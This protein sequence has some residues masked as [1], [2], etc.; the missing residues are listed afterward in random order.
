MT[1]PNDPMDLTMASTKRTRENLIVE[2]NEGTPNPK[3]KK[4]PRSILKGKKPEEN[5]DETKQS[6][7]DAEQ[8]IVGP[9][10]LLRD[11]GKDDATI[12]NNLHTKFDQVH[13]TTASDEEDDDDDQLNATKNKD[14][15]HTH[16]NNNKTYKNNEINNNHT[17]EAHTDTS[18]Q[19]EQQ[20]E[21][22]KEID[23]K[24]DEDN[25]CLDLNHGGF[26]KHTSEWKSITEG[27]MNNS[28]AL[29]TADEAYTTDLLANIAEVMKLHLPTMDKDAWLKVFIQTKDM[30]GARNKKR[31]VRIFG[32][33]LARSDPTTLFSRDTFDGNKLLATTLTTVWAAAYTLYGA[34]WLKD[35]IDLGPILAPTALFKSCA[36]TDI[37]QAKPFSAAEVYDEA[38]DSLH[39]LEITMKK[40]CKVKGKGKAVIEPDVWTAAM[41]KKFKDPTV[42][43]V[44]L[45]LANTP[46]SLFK[47]LQLLNGNALDKIAITTI[48]TG[49]HRLLGQNTPNPLPTQPA[50]SSKT[51]P[52]SKSTPPKAKATE[53]TSAVKF[54]AETKA[55]QKPGN[56]LFISKAKPKP[57]ATLGPASK[58]KYN[59]YYKVK[60]PTT[61]NPFGPKA[62]EE[63]TSHFANLTE[64][65][66]SIDKKAEVLPWYDNNSAKPL[67]KGS[68]DLKTKE[69]L[70]KYTPNV[71]FAQGKNTWLRFHIAHDVNKEKFADTEAFSDAKLQ[72]SYDKVQAKK[73]SIWGWMLGGIPETANLN[74]MKEACENHPLLKAFQ[75]EARSQVIRVFSGKQDTPVHLQVKAIHIIGDDKL[76]AKG[77]KAFNSVFGSRNDSGYPQQRV[78]RFVPNIADNRFPATQ[79]RVK[80][81]VK[82]MGKQKKIV[83]DAKTIYTDTICGLHYYV[84]QIG[85]TLCQILM[86]M[87][88]THDPD[89]Q[90]F[91]AVDE[92]TYGSYAVAFTVHRDRMAE[93]TSLIP[94]LNIVMEAK[95]GASIWEW[96]TD[97][98]KD[99]SQGY[100]YDAILGRL[101][102]MDEEADDDESS[103]ESEEDN[104][105]VIE[106]SESLNLSSAKSTEKGDAFDLDL[107]FMLD[108]ENP[109][110]QYG[111]S[112][113]VKSFKSTCQ[114]KRPIDITSSDEEDDDDSDDMNH[115][116][117]ATQIRKKH[118]KPIEMHI[119]ED[120]SVD[121]SQTQEPSTISDSMANPELAFARMCIQNPDFLARFIK[122]NPEI[123]TDLP[124][125]SPSP[126]PNKDPQEASPT[127]QG[128]EASL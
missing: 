32:V 11:L 72:V 38:P 33:S 119:P 104:D 14:T 52:T 102:N 114:S 75:I 83:K 37:N 64:V 126:A 57:V 80:D 89:T 101:K 66:W 86:S 120:L 10:K 81:V 77:R 47:E 117:P 54:T 53:A 127:D 8:G 88:S 92:R 59:G 74:D 123:H 29:T 125:T 19:E 76:T 61:I 15:K 39:N 94:L 44:C 73:T 110:N 7:D 111:D 96:F 31:F 28:K 71:Y 109:K 116:I 35:T 48:W 25:Y 95:F 49:A 22:S 93:A 113:S 55:A 85:Y 56:R 65:I 3:D 90:L 51:I 107:S 124:G 5:D 97:T 98:A 62:L 9:P 78:M 82:M 20:E 23:N 58:R 27:V 68:D 67:L 91:M 69:Q 118:N 46:V 50:P 41:T 24:M 43:K 121:T 13:S 1:E 40:I 16:N 128:D 84:P 34:G 103:I 115:F 60:L 12:R 26:K 100:V 4:T 105:F 21:S 6:D 122:S 112:G 36:K 17:A 108:D 70:T 79:G 99:A 87:R 106:L 18:G 45:R 63:V 42:K 30:S 2:I